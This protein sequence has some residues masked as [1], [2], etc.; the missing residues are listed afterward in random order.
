MACASRIPVIKIGA[1]LL[2]P[3]AELDRLLGERT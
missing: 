1:R 3:T 2:V